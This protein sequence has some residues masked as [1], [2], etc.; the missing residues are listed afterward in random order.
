MSKHLWVKV[1]IKILSL[2]LQ[3][4]IT[5]YQDEIKFICNKINN[6]YNKITEKNILFT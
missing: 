2:I 4:I 1:F 3:K 5:D 6:I